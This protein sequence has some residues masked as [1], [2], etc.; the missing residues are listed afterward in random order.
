M[1]EGGEEDGGGVDRR[2]ESSHRHGRLR[3]ALPPL[4]PPP[5]AADVSGPRPQ[6]RKRT[7]TLLCLLAVQ[8]PFRPLA[9]EVGLRPVRVA[10][11]EDADGFS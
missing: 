7:H 4:L 2:G 8:N 9:V 11:D 3:Q 6:P 10:G 1:A 5:A